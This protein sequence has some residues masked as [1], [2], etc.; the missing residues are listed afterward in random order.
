MIMPCYNAEKYLGKAIQSVIAQAFAGWELIIVNDGSIDASR[1]IAEDFANRENRIQVVSK[2]NGGYV[3]ARLHGIPYANKESRYFY[4]FDA[5]DVLHPLYLQ[6][7]LGEMEKNSLAGAIYCDHLLIDEND[8]ALNKPLYGQ[9]YIPTL[10]GVK[11]LDEKEPFTPFIS[12]ICWAKIIEPL[13]IIRRKAYEDAGGWDLAFGKGKGNYGEGIVLFGQIALQWKVIYVNQPLYSYRKHSAQF[14]AHHDLANTEKKLSRIW[15]E[16]MALYPEYSRGIQYAL[17]F[18]RSRLEAFKNR[19]RLKH[20]LRFH[21]LHGIGLFFKIIYLYL[22][23]L[24]LLFFKRK[25]FEKLISQ[26]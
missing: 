17:I 13:T 6:T 15:K 21:P 18:K 9:R 1:K 3:S 25:N 24:Q 10:F 2:E 11:E 19:N 16:K 4:F 5:D 8:K 23:S 20:N 22:V 7:L 14:T 26:K 12:I